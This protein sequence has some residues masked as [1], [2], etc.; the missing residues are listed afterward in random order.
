VQHTWCDKLASVPA[1]GIRFPLRYLPT[2]VL[3]ERLAPVM[4][5]WAVKDK[6]NFQ[7]QKDEQFTLE[8]VT[9]DGFIYGF[10][11]GH[12]SVT[13]QHR[14]KLKNNSG[15][16]PSLEMLSKPLP[17]TE[18]VREAIY[19]LKTSLLAIDPKSEGVLDRV[20]LVSSTHVAEQDAPPGLLRLLE[21]IGRPWGDRPEAFDLMFIAQLKK[22]EKIS[23]RCIHNLSRS[24]EEDAL[25][26]AKFDFQRRFEEARSIRGLDAILEQLEEGALAYFEDLA[27]G[28]RFAIN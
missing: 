27:E 18:L 17:Y 19:R 7:V 1:V 20:G 28:G 3:L 22:D 2:A 26:S 10:G 9:D 12:A 21:Y 6:P 13:F 25:I 4:A 15:A 11:P 8:L 5:T 16:S 23:D 24:E 14:M